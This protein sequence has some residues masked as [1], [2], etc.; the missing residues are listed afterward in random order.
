MSKPKS[1]IRDYGYQPNQFDSLYEMESTVTAAGMQARKVEKHS[2]FMSPNE[3]DSYSDMENEYPYPPFT[4]PPTSPVWP[5]TPGYNWPP[6]EEQPS[7]LFRCWAEGCCCNGESSGIEIRCSQPIVKGPWFTPKSSTTTTTD[8]GITCVTTASCFSLAAHVICK[9][10][11]TK[12]TKEMIVYP[13]TCASDVC[14]HLCTDG[15]GTSPGS[16]TTIILPSTQMNVGTSQTLSIAHKAVAR[17]YR[18]KIIS[19]GGTLS[20]SWGDT[21]TYTAPATNP[22]CT[23]SPLIGLYDN[24][25][26]LCDSVTIS[27]NTPGISGTAY[28]HGAHCNSACW[29]GGGV[30]SSNASYRW[31][32]AYD[33]YGNIVGA[34]SGTIT[35]C[36]TCNQDPILSNCAT[37]CGCG[38]LGGWCAANPCT[39][40]PAYSDQRS[41]AMKAAGCCLAVL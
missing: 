20:S 15:T 32:Y 31:E 16:P 25:C 2:E 12:I 38:P 28:Y 26:K 6:T 36:P 8:K 21:T 10:P 13:D 35:G 3:A 9:N 40:S 34:G 17:K 24:G 19:G 7:I 4:P 5:V 33:C 18:W 27:V 39:P 29:E 1:S 22:N 14:S 41:A 11:A 23:S 37:G 30:C